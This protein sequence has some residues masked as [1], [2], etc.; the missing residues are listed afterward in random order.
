VAVG[1]YTQ[2][3]L[4]SFKAQGIGVTVD[5]DEVALAVP[6]NV[7]FFNPNLLEQIGAGP[8]LQALG[9]ESQ[10]NNDESIDNGLRSALFQI[11]TSNDNECLV[12]VESECFTGVNDLGAIDV[13]ARPRPRHRHRTTSSVRRTAC[14]R[15]RRSRPSP[16]SRPTSSRPASPSTPR[17]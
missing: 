12:E 11:P 15:R 14:R 13:G 16:V 3:Q 10:Y 4:A 1:H 5:G 7:A 6:L 8:M 9:A 17:A 2:A